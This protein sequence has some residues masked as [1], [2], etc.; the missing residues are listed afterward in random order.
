MSRGAEVIVA[1]AG[2]FGLSAALALA[3]AGCSVSVW[4]PTNKGQASAVAAG[5]LAPVFEAVLDAETSGDLDL[6]LA[7]R[8][9]W[10]ALATR[11]GIEIDRSGTAAAGS[12][13]WLADIRARLAGMGLRGADLPRSMLA[14]LA[15]GVAPGLDALLVREDWRLEPRPALQALRRAALAAGVAFKPETV[16]E[17]GAADFLVVATGAGQDLA[18]VA[19]EL[20][21][22][23]PIKGQ[24]L[25]FDSRRGGR[26][27]LRGEG[28]YAVPGT[29][30]L[31]IGATM[32]PGR[33]DTAIDA[34]ALEPLVWA[35]RR[36]LP[37]LADAAFEASAGVRAATPDGLP[38]AGPSGTPGVILAVGARRNGWL[39]APL[40]S[41]VVAACV[42]G[43]DSGPYA[44]RLDPSRFKGGW[45]EAGR[46]AR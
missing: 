25:R 27:S 7:A 12:E 43:R 31:A 21:W 11:A 32:E 18:G 42:M 35:A 37:D 28:A 34:A 8:N 30:G 46:A 1:G 17:R 13:A 19:P 9:L 36:L 16:H 3:E 15:P 23:S 20:T 6:L 14:E 38:M 40:V 39:L 45:F 26:I 44:A 5:M 22:L 29:D 4:D 10:P 24:I 33:D 41:Q 2:A